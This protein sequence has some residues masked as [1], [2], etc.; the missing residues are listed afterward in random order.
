M[1]VMSER[2]KCVMLVANALV[3]MVMEGRVCLGP[4]EVRGLGQR[5]DGSHCRRSDLN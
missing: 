5:S 2:V 4:K 1:M 3:L